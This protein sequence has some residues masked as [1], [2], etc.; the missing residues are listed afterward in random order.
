MDFKVFCG[1]SQ[2]RSPLLQLAYGER[3]HNFSPPKAGSGWRTLGSV[4]TGCPVAPCPLNPDM[5]SLQAIPL[6]RRRIVS[7]KG[8][9]IDDRPTSM[10]NR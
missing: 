7:G 10:L 6:R 3:N 2:F 4:R 1:V 5:Q 8:R 9:N